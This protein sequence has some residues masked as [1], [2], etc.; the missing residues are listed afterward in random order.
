VTDVSWS[1]CGDR[2][3]IRLKGLASDARVQVRPQM[4]EGIVGLP[5]MAGH[6]VRDVDDMCF[7]PRFAFVAGTR[8]L[9]VV[10][11][12]AEAELER[13]RAVH[14]STTEVVDIRPTASEVPRNLLRLY[15]RFSAPMAEGHAA[16]HVRF[17]DDSGETMDGVLL[18]TEHELWD[19][20]RRRLTILL[21]PARIKRG[22]LP[23]RQTGYPLRSGASFRVA[24]DE[25]FRDSRGIALR[26]AAERRYRVGEDQRG[27]VEPH[28]WVLQ[29]PSAGTREPLEVSFDRPLDHG[30]L[31]RCVEVIGPDRRRVAAIPEVG[32]E[33]RSWRLTPSEEWVGGSH[34]LVVNPVL[35]DL[36]GNSVSRVFDR[37]L[38]RVEDAPRSDKL[39]TVAFRPS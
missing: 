15:I 24:V 16:S 23:H 13:P 22:L 3:C 20:A 37:D 30:L 19:T 33:E 9:V 10:N 38:S 29:L 5:D 1:R 26:V 8:Y 12:A 21:D 31:C 11:G 2:E 39:V 17:L 36:A 7:V 34:H 25:G 14:P 18:R 32:P 27:R 4:A 6:I 35:E 28:R